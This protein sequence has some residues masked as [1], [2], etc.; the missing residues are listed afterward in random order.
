ADVR[1]R[2]HRLEVVGAAW[3]DPDDAERDLLT[4][5]DLALSAQ[6]LRWD[7]RGHRCR[8]DTSEKEVTACGVGRRA[9]ETSPRKDGGFLLS[10]GKAE[11]PGTLSVYYG[12]PDMAV[13]A[14]AG[15][16]ATNRSQP[17]LH[18]MTFGMLCCT[19]RRQ[20]ISRFEGASRASITSTDAPAGTCGAVKLPASSLK[21]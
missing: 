14:T 17:G 5:R 21:A 4:R 9:H 18:S 6:H 12:H 16:L 7:E 8:R 1:E 19:D 15:L 11:R 3:A 10:E 13:A 2:Q 20:M